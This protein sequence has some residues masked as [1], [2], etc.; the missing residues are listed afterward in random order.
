VNRITETIST[1]AAPA[2]VLVLTVIVNPVY[3]LNWVIS[4][5]REAVPEYLNS[6]ALYAFSATVCILAAALL[7]LGFTS[8]K[9]DLK[10][11]GSVAPSKYIVLFLVVQWTAV[12]GSAWF[13][14]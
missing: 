12:L 5:I 1:L 7:F 6:T 3:V 13:F 9:R 14:L 4:E 2:A 11:H 10:R 8:M